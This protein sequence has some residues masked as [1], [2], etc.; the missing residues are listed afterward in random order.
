MK[1]SESSSAP[2]R[3]LAARRAASSQL[4]LGRFF[5]F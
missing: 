3:R 2:A 4:G 1:S 5:Y